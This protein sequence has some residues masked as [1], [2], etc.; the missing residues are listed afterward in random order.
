MAIQFEIDKKKRVI[1]GTI[2]GDVSRDVL[3]D[4]MAQLH[5]L[6]TNNSDCNLLFDLSKSELE[7]AQ[8]DMYRVIDMV[9]AIISIRE[10]FGEK[11]AHIVPN[12]KDR[13]IHARDIGSVAKIRGINY[14]VFTEIDQ[15]RA[16]LNE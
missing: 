6:T 8:M 3:A 13:I 9:S 4:M 15:A 14:R 11:I 12:R 1:T 10:Q 7:P 2:S 5:I 16:W